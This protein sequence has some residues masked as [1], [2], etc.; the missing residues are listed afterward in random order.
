[1]ASYL[2]QEVAVNHPLLSVTFGMVCFFNSAVKGAIQNLNL[3]QAIIE[4]ARFGRAPA[5]A[6]NG[7]ED[8]TG[9]ESDV[10]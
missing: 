9:V 7:V 4:R 2:A 10:Q 6:E 1:M 3:D 8:D 5:A